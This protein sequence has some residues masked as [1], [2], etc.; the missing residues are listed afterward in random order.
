MTLIINRNKIIYRVQKA[1]IMG[2]YRKRKV[3]KHQITLEMMRGITLRFVKRISIPLFHPSHIKQIADILGEGASE[4]ERIDSLKNLRQVD[5]LIQ[6]HWTMTQL[7]LKLSAMEPRDP[8]ENGSEVSHYSDN[9][10]NDH[11][12]LEELDELLINE[13]NEHENSQQSKAGGYGRRFNE[14]HQRFYKSS[15]K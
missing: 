4:L 12:G 10:Y 8:R 15:K 6:S 3:Y 9:G 5:K 2:S 11:N 1:N 13:E 7:N 14:T